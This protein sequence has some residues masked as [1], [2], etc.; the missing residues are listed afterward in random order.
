M[1]N[2]NPVIVPVPSLVAILLNREREKGS[3]LNEEEV[4]ALRDCAECIAMP[5]DV[6][7]EVAEKRGYD[8]IDPENVWA[9]WKAIRPSLDM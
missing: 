1:S 3:P 7:A 5:P 8:D 6:A 9:A 4:V 2:D